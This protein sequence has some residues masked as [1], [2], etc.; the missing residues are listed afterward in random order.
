MVVMSLSVAAS[1]VV[2]TVVASSVVATVVASSVVAK[3][4]G[5]IVTAEVVTRSGAEKEILFLKVKS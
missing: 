4:V 5:S 2:A 1:S 3:V